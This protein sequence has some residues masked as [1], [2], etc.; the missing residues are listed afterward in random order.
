MRQEEA[1]TM[2]PKET[3]HKTE[4]ANEP[5]LHYH[6]ATANSGL[7]SDI[8]LDYFITVCSKI[9]QVIIFGIYFDEAFVC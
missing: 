8:F 1:G 3:K 9:M 4:S 5:N 6:I 2:M 7:F